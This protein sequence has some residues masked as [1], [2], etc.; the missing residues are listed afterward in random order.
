[1]KKCPFCAEEIQADAL[2]CN[3]N[4]NRTKKIIISLAIIMLSYYLGIMFVK[5]LKSLK[6][7]YELLQPL[8]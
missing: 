6:S 7:Y 4:F 1:M 2:K 3:P 8:Y 5:S